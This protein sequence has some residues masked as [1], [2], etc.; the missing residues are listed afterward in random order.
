M[1]STRAASVPDAAR[2]PIDA[3]HLLSLARW[4]AVRVAEDEVLVDPV[5]HVRQ[6]SGSGA[7]AARNHGGSSAPPMMSNGSPGESPAFQSGGHHVWVGG[8]TG[9]AGGIRDRVAVALGEEG[10]LHRRESS[11]S[12]G[13]GRLRVRPMVTERAT[14]T[15]PEAGRRRCCHSGRTGTPPG[16]RPPRPSPRPPPTRPATADPPSESATET[17]WSGATAGSF[18]RRPR[19][20][21]WSIRGARWAP[22]RARRRR[23][24][25]ARAGGHASRAS[26][27]STRLSAAIA[28]RRAL[29][30]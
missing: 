20:H 22:P 2:R 18:E 30:A 28:A 26:A 15:G 13:S 12:S 11:G 4:H 21:A 29:V 8:A 27:D 24:H 19:S 3:D 25:F 5:V 17:S 14:P 6:P 7:E 1:A 23:R 10:L 9:P 16:P